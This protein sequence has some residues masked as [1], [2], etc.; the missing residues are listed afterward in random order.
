MMTTLVLNKLRPFDLN[1]KSKTHKIIDLFGASLRGKSRLPNSVYRRTCYDQARQSIAAS[2]ERFIFVVGTRGI[3]KSVFGMLLGMDLV[4]DGSI[5]AYEDAGKK[6][7]LVPEV[8]KVDCLRAVND[9]LHEY[10]FENVNNKQAGVYLFV[11]DGERQVWEM[12]M[13]R[14]EMV[15]I[16]DLGD[17]SGQTVFR[18]GD[19]RRIVITSP[20]NNQLKGSHSDSQ[21]S[22]M[23]TIPMWSLEE[24]NIANE[25]VF[26]SPGVRKFDLSKQDMSERYLK[27]GG[28]ARHLLQLSSSD[29]SDKFEGQIAALTFD[30]LKLVFNA[31]GFEN[32]PRQKDTDLLIHLVPRKDETMLGNGFRVTF[33]TDY[34]KGRLCDKLI[35]EWKFELLGFTSAVQQVPML[36]QLTGFLLESFA[37][38]N[39]S[40]PRQKMTISS[41]PVLKKG[42]V[43]QELKLKETTVVRFFD[44]MLT[45]LHAVKVG[46]YYQPVKKVNEAFDSFMMLDHSIAGKKVVSSSVPPSS[47]TLSSSSTTKTATID[48]YLVFFQMTVS[49][50]HPVNGAAIKRVVDKVKDLQ[51]TWNIHTELVFISTPT[52]IRTPQKLISSSGAEYTSE[53]ATPAVSQFV[54]RM[55]KYEDYVKYSIK[56]E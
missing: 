47:E 55:E 6:M 29:L 48:M 43:W 53:S 23:I 5:V 45:D 52:G 38:A 51:R 30:Q 12:L 35:K 28:V 15:H 19:A 54:M 1:A 4:A 49:D 17:D 39:L 26:S 40:N 7:L 32:I 21:T 36:G 14:A 10:G 22:K 2:D 11:S 31:A 20:N 42:A 33:A 24:L 18:D 50:S 46:E 16:Q 25:Q 44:E 37:H 8:P 27:F 56:K 41:L 9:T 34:V 13:T 3:G